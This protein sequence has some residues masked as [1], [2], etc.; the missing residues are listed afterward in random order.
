MRKEWVILVIQSLILLAILFVFCVFW[1]PIPEGV[2]IAAF[3]VEAS[4]LTLLIILSF[5]RRYHPT[6]LFYQQPKERGPKPP[7][8]WASRGG[9][10][11]SWPMV[12]VVWPYVSYAASAEGVYVEDGWGR[13]LPKLYIPWTRVM[14]I[15]AVGRRG[16]R[17]YTSTPELVIRATMV[18]R[19]SQ[20]LDLAE[21][22]GVAVQRTSKD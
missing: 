22:C 12:L 18:R 15:E 6:L 3:S 10:R 20:L 21:H 17:L 16:F 1:L 19:M 14:R 7:R 8:L 4:L 9:I 11:T 13:Y 2:R 5:W